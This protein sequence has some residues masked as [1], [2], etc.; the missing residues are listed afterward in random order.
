MPFTHISLSSI[1]SQKAKA[2]TESIEEC[3]EAHEKINKWK[4]NS[5]K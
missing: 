2:G 1:E 3:S 5:S 4:Y